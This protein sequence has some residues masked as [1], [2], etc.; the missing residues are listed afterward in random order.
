[1]SKREFWLGILCLAILV[2]LI[3]LG[4]MIDQSLLADSYIH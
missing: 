2:G 4:G 1:M 3:M